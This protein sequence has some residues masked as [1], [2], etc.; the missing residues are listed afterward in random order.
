MTTV[1][2]VQMQRISLD[3]IMRKIARHQLLAETGRDP[4]LAACHA[5]TAAR[6]EAQAWAA[7]RFLEKYVA[8]VLPC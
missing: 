8:E 3:A 1:F 7:E 4:F 2:D 5:S 6:L